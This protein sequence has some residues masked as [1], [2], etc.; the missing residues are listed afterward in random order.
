MSY[1]NVDKQAMRAGQQPTW[2]L[3]VA[4]GAFVG[5]LCVIGSVSA[6]TGQTSLFTTVGTTATANPVAM[7]VPMGVA[8]GAARYQAP[9]MAPQPLRSAAVDVM[10]GEYVMTTTA[11]NGLSAIARVG[12][13]VAAPVLLMVAFLAKVFSRSEVSPAKA[14]VGPT[15]LDIV[16]GGADACPA[17]ADMAYPDMIKYKPKCVHP[18]R[19]V[20]KAC[21][22]C[23][24]RK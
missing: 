7:Q 24:R 10:G 3:P 12:A 14:Y 6:L 17:D 23:P 5:T 11:N 8:P 9:A 16:G 22:D 13:F 18:D 19:P 20:A 21:A 4:F 15:S 2:S 1:I